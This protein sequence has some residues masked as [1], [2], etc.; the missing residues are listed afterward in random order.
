MNEAKQ[1]YNKYRGNGY[2]EKEFQNYNIDPENITLDD[3]NDTALIWDLRQAVKLI[4]KVNYKYGKYYLKFIYLVNRFSGIPEFDA[5]TRD[6]NLNDKTQMTNKTYLKKLYDVEYQIQKRAKTKGA[7][8]LDYVRLKNIYQDNVAIMNILKP[9]NLDI[10]Y[11]MNDP[12]LYGEIQMNIAEILQLDD[13]LTKDQFI[14]MLNVAYD[15]Y[16]KSG[17]FQNYWRFRLHL[18][19]KLPL[20]EMVTQKYVDGFGLG[21]NSFKR[22]NVLVERIYTMRNDDP[23][24]PNDSKESKGSNEYNYYPTESSEDEDNPMKLYEDE[25]YQDDDDDEYGVKPMQTFES[26]EEEEEEEEN[27]LKQLLET[28]Y[29]KKEEKRRQKS[30]AVFED[31]LKNSNPQEKFDTQHNDPDPFD[32]PD[33]FELEVPQQPRP[34]LH[35]PD[36]IQPSKII[37]DEREAEAKRLL[38]QGELERENEREADIRRLRKQD[39]RYFM[40]NVDEINKR[41]EEYSGK[42]LT[43]EEKLATFNEYKEWVRQSRFEKGDPPIDFEEFLKFEKQDPFPE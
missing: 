38:E 33:P 4:Q 30:N 28:F 18:P 9:I 19:K 20:L 41:K 35:T 32:D 26:D 1:I 11:A 13:R 31:L 29:A 39:A 24:L 37:V 34:R 10:F 6:L 12:D 27:K 21:Q 40:N 42:P 36:D 16:F 23:M 8:Y 7:F 25:S 5:A 2:I 17:I 22:F 43:Y 15:L 3:M 14:S